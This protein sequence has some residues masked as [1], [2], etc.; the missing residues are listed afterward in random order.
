MSAKRI[1]PPVVRHAR[2][3]SFSDWR[4]R[5]D[6]V[7]ID[8]VVAIVGTRGKT[9][10]LR[11]FES[12]LLADDI[13]FATWTDAGVEIEGQ[14]Q[15]GELGPWSRALTR[16]RA[17]GLDIAL[18]EVDWPTVPVLGPPNGLFPLVAVTNLCANS[19][20]C[21]ITPEMLQAKQALARLRENIAANGCLVVNAD[22]FAVAD[23]DATAH[24][25][26]LFGLS[27]D[28]PILRRHIASGGSACWVD[29]G[30]VSSQVRGD[31]QRI[32]HVDEL[33]WTRNGTIGFAVQNA[34]L[35]T[36]IAC[37]CGISS[38][39][40]A[41]GLKSH[42]AIAERTPGAFN[43]YETHAGT[44]IIDV[45]ASSWFLRSTVRALSGFGASRQIRIAGPML[46]VATDDLDDVGRLLGRGGGVLILHGVWDAARLNAVR[47][48]AAST[49]VPP[50]V[51]QAVDERSAV[52]QGLAM[53]RADDIMLILAEQPSAVVK[54]VDRRLRRRDRPLLRAPGAA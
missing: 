37:V 51:I 40:I 46:N 42:R 53:L 39:S 20:A 5:L 43:I 3:S 34:L 12:I 29:K 16:L 49:E 54:L 8:P 26:F 33:L 28:T 50:L 44:V 25:R 35:A 19:E 36:A 22:D 38:T 1:A 31:A 47:Q 9:S 4:A 7:R 23:G 30:V 48:G 15:R 27:P 17:G 18:Q 2:A 6:R 32:V 52:Q 41:A 10:A 24:E 11:V 45:P 21:L 13:R 14:H